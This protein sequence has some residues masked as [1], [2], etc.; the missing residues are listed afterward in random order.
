MNSF[1]RKWMHILKVQSW[2]KGIIFFFSK[3]NNF[4][5][6]ERQNTYLSSYQIWIDKIIFNAQLIFH[7]IK[8]SKLK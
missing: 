3:S 8:I 2:K 5:L 4:Y 6:N 1:F 7:L